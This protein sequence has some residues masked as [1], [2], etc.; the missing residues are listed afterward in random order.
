[1]LKKSALILQNLQVDYCPLGALEV[2]VGNLVVEK[3]NEL[4]TKFEQVIAAI[5]WHPANHISFAGSH[6]WRKIGQ[7]M[8]IDGLD[9]KLMPFHCVADSFGARL[10]PS[11][12][13]EKI[14]Q[15]IHQGIEVNTDNY[16]AFFDSDQ[17]RDTGLSDYLNSNKI[18]RVFVMGLGIEENVK[19]TVLDALS[20]NYK[21]VVIQD[22]CEGW[23]QNAIKKAW[24]EMEKEGAILVN[25][26]R[27]MLLD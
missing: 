23:E 4:M 9:Q 5:D 10:Y 20:L 2:P 18:E 13:K 1:M 12:Q 8:S 6:M 26:D 14:T 21:V 25:A 7:T 11:L 22:A 15:I 17:R 24:K 16:S 19:Y 27:I 3:A